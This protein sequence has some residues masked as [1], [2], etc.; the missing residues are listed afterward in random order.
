[1]VLILLRLASQYLKIGRFKVT[2]INLKYQANPGLVQ[3]TSLL[4]PSS[5]GLAPY[6]QTEDTLPLSQLYLKCMYIERLPTIAKL[7]I[8]PY[9]T[10]PQQFLGFKKLSFVGANQQL[11][12]ADFVCDVAV[13]TISIRNNK[14]KLKRG[15]TV[16]EPCLFA[17]LS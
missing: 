12:N 8:S 13:N 16:T 3:K 9:P 15:R 11:L 4:N 1:M 17:I 7:V 10:I 6:A 5:L 2:Q 14:N